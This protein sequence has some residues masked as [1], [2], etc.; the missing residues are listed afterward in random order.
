MRVAVA[1]VVMLSATIGGAHAQTPVRHDALGRRLSLHDDGPTM[2]A[3]N[4]PARIARVAV[5]PGSGGREAWGLGY[6]Y[7][8]EPGFDQITPIGQIVFLHYTAAGG[9]RVQG[10]PLDANGRPVNPQLSTLAVAANGEGYAVGAQGV[11]FHHR[12]GG[13]WRAHPST[14]VTRNTLYSVSLRADGRGVYGFAVGANLTFLRLTTGTWSLDLVNGSVPAPGG[15][16]PN[17]ASVATVSRERAWAVSGSNSN[18]L[19]IFERSSGA[20][21]RVTT[22]N[23]IFDSPPAP[24][25]TGDGT[26]TI[27][28]FAR[29]NAVAVGSGRVWISGMMQPVDASK[30]TGDTSGSDRTRPFV[31]G[32]T[33]DGFT[34]WCPPQYQLSSSG[35]TRTVPLCDA[36]FPYATGD[37]PALAVTGGEVFAG[38]LGLFHYAGGT[39]RREPSVLGYIASASFES[40]QQGWL[41]T[42][43]D[44][45]G[46]TGALSA[47]SI[48]LGH[49]TTSKPVVYMARWPHPDDQTLEAIALDPAGSGRAFAVGRA[50]ALVELTPGI[51]WDRI[52]TP[53]DAALLGLAWPARDVGWAVGSAGTILRFDG[54]GWARDD[55]ASRLT[56]A[57]LYAVAFDGPD[58]GI[59]VG[60]KGTVVRYAAGRWRLADSM[61]ERK[62]SAVAFA[63][64]DAIAVGDKGTILI[65]R[66]AGLRAFTD[67]DESLRS[68]Q[69]GEAP[70]LLSVAGLADG[71][72]LIGGARSVLITRTANG[73]ELGRQPPVEGAIIALA[74]QRGPDGSLRAIASVGAGGS[75]Y[76]GD[77]PATSAGWLFA[78]NQGAWRDI[79]MGRATSATTAVDAP[80]LRD[81][82]YAIA[83]DTFGRMGWAV[84]GYPADVFGEDG[85]LRATPTASIWRVSSDGAAARAPGDTTASLETTRGISFA[86]I[87]D[88]SCASGLCTQSIGT[89]TAGDVVLTDAFRQIE[90]AAADGHIR[91]LAFGGD[92]RRNG[93]PDELEPFHA[94]LRELSVPAFAAIGDKDLASGPAVDSSGVL[95]SN[96]YYL[97]AFRSR[98]L[99]WGETSPPKGF[100][101]V[102]LASSPEASAGARTHYAFDYAPAGRAVLR[103][104]FLDTSRL[105][106]AASTQAQNPPEEQSGWLQAVLADAQTKRV[107]SIVVMHQ[108]VVLPVSTSS[109]ASVITGILTAGT[110]SAVLASHLRTNEIVMAPNSSV[111]DALPVGVFGGGGSPLSNH[112]RPSA[113]AYRSWQ[114]ITVDD[115]PSARTVTGRALVT[116]R[117]IPVLESVALHALDGRSA[118]AGAARL[119]TGLGRAPDMGSA[120]A[121]GTASDQNQGRATYLRFPFPERCGVLDD[122]E[123][124][125]TGAHVAIPEFSFVSEDPDIAEFVRA[126][127]ADPTRPFRNSAG[128]LVRDDQ[129]GLL[130][131]LRPGTT[132]IRLQAGTVASRIPVRVDAGSG[133]CIPGVFAEVVG[134]PLGRPAVEQPEPAVR[135]E[136]PQPNLLRPRL[137]QTAAIAAIAPPIVNAAP[138]PPAGGGGQRQEEQQAASER[139]DMTALAR[140]TRPTQ[141]SPITGVALLA[142]LCIAAFVCARAARAR[143]RPRPVVATVNTGR[144]YR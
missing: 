134:D 137:P 115:D 70:N 85:H 91:F 123:D 128:K 86:F 132:A 28:Q 9:W 99:P 127:P 129:S 12:S 71:T 144:T 122:P 93:L 88:T 59:A 65:D 64:R 75:R 113:G 16:V 6:S 1:C 62:L 52:A 11:I 78:L 13:P 40:P 41:A 43:G 32:S 116:M 107:P 14:G 31:L 15:N 51:G 46:G 10:P 108:P 94:L 7:A 125:C 141:P 61:T 117:S 105:P 66:G 60:E 133:P 34:S 77:L 22:G 35:V 21:Q 68:G 81:A 138:A 24:V 131:T 45:V 48:T 139:A 140:R 112:A 4:A 3:V 109:D 50:G 104:A 136:D 27:N 73:F 19:L 55:A 53:V 121:L 2:R 114:I 90:A 101:P 5:V 76:N 23:P 106:L 18:S 39:W 69:E 29:G 110:A 118:P 84:G 119:F 80:V 103:V 37:L 100:Q 44:V 42:P 83:L 47:S 58:R 89:G 72:A 56:G 30:P 33:G 143:R 120:H 36:A 25:A 97:R 17:L 57:R 38:G 96:G 49:W 54:R 98:P 8:R 130:C 92:M 95:S 102:R 87:G 20:W 79:S 82:V 67:L 63:G 126:D 135:P 111:P 124:G 142:S 74:A 26:G